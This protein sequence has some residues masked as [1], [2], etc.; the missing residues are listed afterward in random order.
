MTGINSFYPAFTGTYAQPF[1]SMGYNYYGM[2]PA[3]AQN[4][5]DAF[6]S[7]N[8]SAKAKKHPFKAMLSVIIPG[9]GE[10]LNGD[11]AK[12][13]MHAGAAFGFGS[14]VYFLSK[15]IAKAP[16]LLKKVGKWAAIGCYAANALAAGFNAL[17][18]K[19]SHSEH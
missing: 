12:A 16:S 14:A 2:N 19:S 9:S 7:A 4:N 17:Y 1:D 10:L 5:S 8:E 18:T 15:S 6:E 13:F 11:I 3:F